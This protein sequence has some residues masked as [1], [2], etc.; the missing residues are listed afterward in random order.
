MKQPPLMKIHRVDDGFSRIIY[1]GKNPKG[2]TVYYAITAWRGEYTIQRLSQDGE[3]QCNAT[4]KIPLKKL[5][6]LPT[7]MSDLCVGIRNFIERN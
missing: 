1:S 6:E 4:A 5:F 2:E 7:G 3:A